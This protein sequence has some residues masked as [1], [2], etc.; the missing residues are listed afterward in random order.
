MENNEDSCLISFEDDGRGVEDDQL[1]RLFERFYRVDKGRSRRMGGTGL[2]LAIVKHAVQFHG[3][4]V[5]VTNR[6][7]GGLRFEF[8]LQK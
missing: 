5:S 6:A 4:N 2:G 8:S 7:E 3:G 1:P